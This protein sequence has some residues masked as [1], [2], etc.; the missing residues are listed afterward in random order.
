MNKAELCIILSYSSHHLSQVFA[1]SRSG[2]TI[3]L[4]VQA[5]EVILNLNILKCLLM[6]EGPESI[7]G[8]E[9]KV[10]SDNGKSE[11]PTGNSREGYDFLEEGWKNPWGKSALAFIL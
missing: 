10:F 2:T 3:C 8:M 4:V 6:T 5:H 11:D 9:D 7:M 1:I